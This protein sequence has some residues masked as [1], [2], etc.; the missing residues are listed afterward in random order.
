[1]C[2]CNAVSMAVKTHYGEL[3]QKSRDLRNAGTIMLIP[4]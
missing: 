4:H 2:C 3:I 1:M